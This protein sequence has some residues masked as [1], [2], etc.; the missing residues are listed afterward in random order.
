MIVTSLCTHTGREDWL[1]PVTDR[2][3][4]GDYVVLEVCHKHAGFQFD[5]KAAAGLAGKPVVVL[6]YLEYGWRK[7]WNNSHLVGRNSAAAGLGEEY[8][9]LDEWLAGQ[10]VVAYFKRELTPEV[11]ALET[12]FP[13]Y[14]VELLAQES[15]VRW[16]SRNDWDR[17]SG[18]IFHLYGFS[19]MDRKRLHG[20]LQVEF[21][22]TVNS[23]DAVEHPGHPAAD[24]HYL[25]QREHWSRYDMPR[26]L[27][28]QREFALSI[29]LPGAGVKTFRDGEACNG[30]VPVFADVGMKRAIPWTEENAILLPTVNGELRI[31]ESVEILRAALSDRTALYPKAQSALVNCIRYQA[32]KYVDNHINRHIRAHL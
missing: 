10:H 23:L 4:E 1:R 27:A 32:E 26:V 13:V 22:T 12:S 16:F 19:H 6:D 14:P 21:G 8:T 28:A 31:H 24:W 3:A 15:E 2:L 7:S 25:E 20:A 30:T 5:H 17:R 9:K 11:Q 18:G 29:A